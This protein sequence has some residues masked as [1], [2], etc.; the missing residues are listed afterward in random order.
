MMSANSTFFFLL[1]VKQM[2]VSVDFL[3]YELF[4]Q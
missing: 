2:V 4:S 3:L 1:Y